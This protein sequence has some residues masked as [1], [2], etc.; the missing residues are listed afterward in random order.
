[1][2]RINI[3]PKEVALEYR[4]KNR[5]VYSIRKYF[6]RFVLA[7]I[8]LEISLFAVSHGIR[9]LRINRL[10]NSFKEIKEEIGF[11][12]ARLNNKEEE[13]A[14]IKSEIEDIDKKI[15]KAGERPAFLASIRKKPKDYSDILA[16][17]NI[18]SPRKIWIMYL[19]TKGD[20]LSIIGG[21]YSTLLVTRFMSNLQDSPFF[22]N[23]D[24]VYTK[25]SEIQKVEV[26][27][28]EI[29]C[30]VIRGRK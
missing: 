6:M 29:S 8:I 4:Y 16:E 15:E 12:L 22:T 9:G 30:D 19:S 1:M 23:A 3:L 5:W 10:N 11:L 14:R 7:I 21:S 2:K 17:V 20:K 18:E 13:V 26:V 28:F 24:F 25:K 27:E